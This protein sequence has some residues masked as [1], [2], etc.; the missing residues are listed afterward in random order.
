MKKR[1]VFEIGL[2]RFYRQSTKLQFLNSKLSYRKK[3]RKLMCMNIVLVR[4]ILK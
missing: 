2:D 4:Y 1:H 3:L